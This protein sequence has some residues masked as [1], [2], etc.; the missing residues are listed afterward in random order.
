[1]KKFFVF[2]LALAFQ[3]FS[4]ASELAGTWKYEKAADALGAKSTIPPFKYDTIQIV[5]SQAGL[6]QNCFAQLQKGQFDFPSVFRPMLEE[7]MEEEHLAAFLKK[8]FGFELVANPDF[9]RLP[10]PPSCR[11]KFGFALVAGDKLLVP[12]AGQTVYSFVRTDGAFSPANSP[13]LAGHVQTQ[14]PFNLNNFFELCGKKIVS[15]DGK[16]QD[17]AKCGPVYAPYIA[18]KDS[19][20]KLSQLVGN[21]NYLKGGAE[22]SQDYAPPFAKNL[23]PAYLVLPPLKDVLVLR[24]EDMETTSK[25][26]RD[27]MGGVYLTIQAGKVTDQLN[28]ACNIDE[29]HFCVAQDGTK[30]YQLQESGKFIKLK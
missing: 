4:M 25:S 18:R 13:I 24:V 5:G 27:T 6:G 30:L 10:N 7:N 9:Y 23:S 28:S 8:N 14:L 3:S 11:G 21:H 12:V 2:S 20:D 26:G 22:Y 15:P 29:Q 19:D 1:M 16:V 17:S